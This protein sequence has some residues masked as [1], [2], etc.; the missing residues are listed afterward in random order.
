MHVRL[1][2]NLDESVNDYLSY[3][4]LCGGVTDL[5]PVQGVFCLRLRKH[6]W[7]KKINRWQSAQ[8]VSVSAGLNIVIE[9]V[10]A[11]RKGE[12]RWSMIVLQGLGALVQRSR[13]MRVVKDR[14]GWRWT[15]P[16]VDGVP[17]PVLSAAPAEHQPPHQA[18][19]GRG[20]AE[21]HGQSDLV[22]HPDGK[23]GVIKVHD[24]VVGGPGHGDEAEEAGAEKS[25]PAAQCQSRF[26]GRS[27]CEAGALHAHHGDQ[28]GQDWGDAGEHHE[29]AGGLKNDRVQT[30]SRFC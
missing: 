10:T 3:L 15:P 6:K 24:H 22:A 16:Q 11:A 18:E 30:L 4:P 17:P 25:H 23:E 29:S 19:A 5:Q 14:R 21:V 26:D 13:S 28:R 8:C 20:V 7:V 9:S 12:K 1:I 27:S 2:G